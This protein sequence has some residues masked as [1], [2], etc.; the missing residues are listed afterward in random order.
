MRLKS[1]TPNWLFQKNTNCIWGSNIIFEGYKNK[2]MKTKKRAQMNYLST[3][4]SFSL[5]F[6][7]NTFISNMF[8]IDLEN[9][10]KKQEI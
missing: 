1:L 4:F 10:L 8:S 2:E 9:L 5:G 3:Y 7:G 6:P